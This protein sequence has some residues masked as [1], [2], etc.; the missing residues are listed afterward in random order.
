MWIAET[1]CPLEHHS[2]SKNI[3]KSRAIHNIITNRVYSGIAGGH[4]RRL[5]FV[6][7][8]HPALHR[9][10]MYDQYRYRSARPEEGGPPKSS[11]ARGASAAEG[12]AVQSRRR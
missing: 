1:L 2:S 11:A 9:A 8:C 4:P 3:S 6:L 10:V 7:T 5:V 12:D